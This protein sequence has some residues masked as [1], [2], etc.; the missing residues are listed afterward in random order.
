M[1]ISGEWDPG[2]VTETQCANGHEC[3][4]AAWESGY[5]VF[6]HADIYGGGFCET[7][8]GDWLKEHP[9]ARKAK[10][11]TKAGI[12]F[13]D[14][15]RWDFSKDWIVKSCESSLKRLGVEVIDVYLLH[16]PDYLMDPGE[17]GEAFDVLHRQGKAKYFGVS[18]FVPSKVTALQK[19]LGH[20]LISN[21]IELSLKHLEP[22]AD[23]TMDQC[24]EL[25]LVAMVWSPLAGGKYQGDPVSALR[26]LLKHPAKVV[27][28]VGTAQPK[29]VRALS[30]A[31]DVEMSREDW[32]AL[33]KEAQ[34]HG[35]P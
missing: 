12:R 7:L 13:D 35:L 10:V 14:P 8:Y 19:H 11:V 32:Y 17:V 30:H 31:P 1:R 6:D 26:W 29:R 34:G 24:L 2:K 18:N 3:L 23:G 25:D 9:E 4:T 21:Q 20:K 15:H 22:L 5:D 33:L 16:R 27:P 28:V